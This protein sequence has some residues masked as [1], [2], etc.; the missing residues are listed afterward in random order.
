V[1]YFAVTREPGPAWDHARPMREQDG[2][3]EHAA[4][5]DGLVTDRFLLLGGPLGDG[6]RFFHVV[7]AET[8]TAVEA[9]LAEDPWAPSML[10]NASIEP[11]EVVLDTREPD[12]LS[13]I[14]KLIFGTVRAK[15]LYVAAKLGIAD[16]LAD[17]P[18]TVDELARRTDTHAETLYRLLRA[19]AAERLF[20]E[21]EPRTFAVTEVGRLISE[22]APG[23]RKYLS[24]MFAE[25]TDRAFDH[26]LEV[27]RTG[28]PGAEAAFGKPYWEWLGDDPGAAETFNRAMSAGATYRL[29]ALLELDIWP[30]ARHVIDVGG[31]DGT[32]VAAL[33]KQH[34]HLRGT[35]FD[36]PHAEAE[37]TARLAEGGFGGRATFEAGSFFEAVPSGGDVYVL[38][39]VLHN[40]GDEEATRILRTIRGATATDARLVVIEVIVEGDD[41]RQF[42]SDLVGLVVLGGRERTESEWRDLLAAGGFEVTRITSGPRASAIEA[43]PV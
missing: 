3:D 15:T 41:D 43:R 1:P 20:D 29:P 14:L 24:I 32:A 36:L 30:N 35:V 31:G 8:Q 42:F 18:L 4:F 38:L 9:R 16:Q 12:N 13:R 19:L 5:M 23:S 39:Q 37:A 2:W 26:L 28:K 33:L 7:E 11:W 21:V 34:P 17:G 27:V 25:Q 40:W 10:R 6:S 22:D